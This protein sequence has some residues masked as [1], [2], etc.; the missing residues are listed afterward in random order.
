MVIFGIRSFTGF[1]TTSRPNQCDA[2][3]GNTD[4][5]PPGAQV[6]KSVYAGAAAR[7][8]KS[9]MLTALKKSVFPLNDLRS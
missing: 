2:R 9:P 5:P 1:D 8:L 4:A 7:T 3:Q 6:R